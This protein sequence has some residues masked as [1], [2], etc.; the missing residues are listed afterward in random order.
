MDLED[1]D[2]IDLRALKSRIRAEALGRRDAMGEEARIEASLSIAS[3]LG[4][5]L[6]FDPG[7]I[8]S[9]FLPIRS[10]IDLRP[11]MARL[12]ERGARLCVPA[13]VGGELEFR[14]LLRGAPLVP[15]GFGTL[16]PGEDAAVLDPQLMLVPLSAFDARC[17][18]IGYGRGY[19]DRAITRLRTM[20]PSPRLVGTA[21]AVQAVERVPTESHDVALD[22]VAT[23]AGIVRPA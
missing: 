1:S 22:M 15:Q 6:D 10:E 19:Y 23:E 11:L 18:R 8:V 3:E 2:A 20:G 4:D 14:E 9:G 16:A 13:I 5:G 12:A 17:H 7:T 21:F